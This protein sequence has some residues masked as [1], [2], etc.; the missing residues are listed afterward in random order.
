MIKVKLRQLLQ[1]KNITQKELAEATNI[2]PSTISD[3]CNNVAERVK[4]EYL[5]AICKALNCEIPDILVLLK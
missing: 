4:F 2:R 3:L 5:E 1:A